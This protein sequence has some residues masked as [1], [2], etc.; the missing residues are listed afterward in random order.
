MEALFS[1]IL[2]AKDRT[3]F[4]DVKEARNKS[5]YLTI[6]ESKKSLNGESRFLRSEIVVFEGQAEE[7]REA[8]SEAI[9]LVK[10]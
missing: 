5:R 3:Y 9:S 7:F 1:R 8:L 4:I 6:A 10:G 2:K